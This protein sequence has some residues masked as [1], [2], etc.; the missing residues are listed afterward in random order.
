VLVCF[1]VILPHFNGGASGGNNYWYRYAWAGTSPGDALKNLVIHPWLL[2]THVLGSPPRRGYIAMVLR[3]GGGLGILAPALLIPALPE[4]AINLYSSHPEQYSGFFQYNAMIVAFFFAAAVYGTVALVDAVSRRPAPAQPAT[5][6]AVP[7]EGIVRRVIAWISAGS[8]AA[9]KHIPARAA[10]WIGLLVIVWLAIT[11]YWNLASADQRLI[12]FWNVGGGPVPYQSQVDDLL[13]RI[14]ASA[15]VAATDTLDPHLSDR[16]NLYLLPDPESFQAEYVAFDIPHAVQTSQAQ[17]QLI[18]N[19][20]TFS[21]R[22][23]RVGTV[24][25]KSGEVVVLQRIGPPISPAT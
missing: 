8:Q 21:R 11:C 9:L 19:E 3:T 1:L 7:A 15:S 20:M 25:Y 10:S 12:N 6:A 13:A 2:I 22:Y 23:R 17:D 16:Y 18:Y 14:P 4:L 24:R 5:A